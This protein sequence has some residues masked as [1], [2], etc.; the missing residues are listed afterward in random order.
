LDIDWVRMAETID[1]SPPNYEDIMNTGDGIYFFDDFC[2][3]PY[4]WSEGD[5][6]SSLRLTPSRPTSTVRLI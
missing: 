1:G 3:K 5:G 6:P 2:D 4:S